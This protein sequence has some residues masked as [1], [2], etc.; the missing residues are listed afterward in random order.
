MNHLILQPTITAQWHALVKE[1]ENNSHLALGEELE[2][3]LVFLLV[4]FTAKPEIAKSV[5]GL[6][7]LRTSHALGQQKQ[8]E[9]REVADKCLLIAGLFPG[10]A[11]RRRVRI[12]YFVEL[13]QSAYTVLATLSK[14]KLAELYQS[15]GEG[16]VPLM[17][18]LH[19]VRELTNEEA[20]LTPLQAEEL[21]SDTAS[22][23]ALAVLRRYTR[24]MSLK[25]DSRELL[26]KRHWH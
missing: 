3:Y 8:Y 26:I 23:H 11:Q 14:Q 19:G 15:L 1:A 12:S 20:G 18:T 21:W 16:F 5:L 4:R 25:S 24:A 10:R 7:F 9:L 6:D 17:D 13:G 22:P 2:S